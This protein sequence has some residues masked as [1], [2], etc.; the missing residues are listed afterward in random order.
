MIRICVLLF[1]LGL[2]GCGFA[3]VH[4]PGGTGGV[5]Q[6]RVL[7]DEPDDRVGFLLVQRLEDRLGRADIPAFRLAVDLD[8]REEARA[9]DPE[10]DIRRFHVI[11]SAAYTLSEDATGTVVR[12]DRVDSFVGYSATGTTVATLAAQRDAQERLMTILADQI[13][14]RLQA[15]PL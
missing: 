10:G 9:I 5:L 6:N 11:G 3:P 15:S 13:V 12:A 1:T 2:A 8:V 14:L 7:V 4:G